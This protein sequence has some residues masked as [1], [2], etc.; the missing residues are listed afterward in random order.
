[1]RRRLDWGLTY[2]RNALGTGA[3]VVDN[4]GNVLASYPAKLF[5]NL[6]Q[7]NLNFP[8]DVSKSIRLTT[9]IR[10][11]NLAVSNVDKY[12]ATIENQQKLYAVTHLEF[13]YDNSLN[14]MNNIM[15]GL[16]YK[17][18][19]DWNR[20]VKGLS[21]GVGPT[22]FNFGF[23]VRYYYPIYKNFIWAGRAAGDFSWG[24]QKFIYYLGGVDG[25]LMFGNNVKPGTTRERYFNTAN[26]PAKNVNY[27][28]QSLALNMRG[29]I[30]NVANG[31]NA[32][33][34]NSELRMP[35]LST[36]FDRTANNAF[37]RDLQIILKIT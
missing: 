30:Q 14:R 20:Q 28:F 34:I 4:Q 23:D 6:Y 21:E 12:S 24:N 5:T 25:W 27:A 33:V 17:G 13:V 9:G 7:A 16:R 35:V 32:V 18:F 19:I 37:L 10:S 1:M 29:Y 11:D 31:N 15:N 22:T 2:Y 3:N 36:L 8:F 26:Q